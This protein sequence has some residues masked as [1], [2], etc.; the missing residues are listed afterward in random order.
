MF[1]GKRMANA[2]LAELPQQAR[3]IQKTEALT[4]RMGRSRAEQSVRANSV[5]TESQETLKRLVD[6]SDRLL[7]TTLSGSVSGWLDGLSSAGLW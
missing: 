2:Q 4:R 6:M 3:N 5:I 7:P 1:A